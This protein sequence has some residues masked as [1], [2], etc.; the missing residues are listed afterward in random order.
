MTNLTAG[1]DRTVSVADVD[2]PLDADSLREHLVGRDAYRRT[3]FLIAMN[4]DKAALLRVVRPPSDKLF[5]PVRDIEL[6]ARAD[7]CAV[8]HAPDVDTA[9]PTQM[10]RAATTLAPGVRCV[11]VRGLYEHVNFIL[12]PDPIPIRIVEV[13][14]PSPAKL[15]DQA[16][17]VMELAEHLPPVELHPEVLNLGDL[18]RSHPS[19]RYLFPC[20]G[21]GA[22]SGEAEVSYLD[23]HPVQRD[24]VLVGC[25]R[26]LQIHRWFYGGEP[27]CV[28]MCP[29]RRAE[30]S[31]ILTLTKCCLL[32]QGLERDGSVVTVPWGAT[33][34]EVREGLRV[35]L[36]A[37]ARWAPG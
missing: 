10:A 4:G 6:L 9:V 36:D 19:G 15:V 13:D 16:A 27:P 2:G 34:D 20:R 23:Q 37:E 35:L 24:W 8:V 33:L 32:E 29:R 12:D 31:G 11:I 1:H 22:V 30:P 14:P 17:R 18:A 21:S 28:D 25:T 26:S 5:S 3:E 7:E